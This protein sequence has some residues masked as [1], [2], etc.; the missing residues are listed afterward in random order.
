MRREDSFKSVLSRA[1]TSRASDANDSKILTFNFL[2]KIDLFKLDFRKDSKVV[3]EKEGE[4]F[5]H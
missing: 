3:E 1:F 5:F 4:V 2:K